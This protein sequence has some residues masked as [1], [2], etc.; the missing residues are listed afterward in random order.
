MDSESLGPE[1][2][3]LLHD[4]F[5]KSAHHYTKATPV[6]LPSIILPLPGCSN[7]DRFWNI[8]WA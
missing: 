7:N 6:M 1:G 4:I 2:F 5:S 3:S 8:I